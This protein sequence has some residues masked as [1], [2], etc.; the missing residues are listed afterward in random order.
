MI[1]LDFPF[2]L[3]RIGLI[4]IKFPLSARVHGHPAVPAPRRAHWRDVRGTFG[5]FA[6]FLIAAGLAGCAGGSP[7][8][9]SIP[10]PPTGSASAATP[11]HLS[12]ITDRD[13]ARLKDWRSTLMKAVADARTTD[14]EAVR[15]GGALFQPDAAL[16]RPMPPA[17]EYACSVAKLGSGHPGLLHFVA[18]PG[19]RCALTAYP[20][21]TAAFVKRTGSQRPVGTLYPADALHAVFLGTLQLS[22]ERAVLP[23]GRDADRDLVARVERI[24]PARWR[25]IF[26]APVYES[27]ADVIELVPAG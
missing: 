17:G 26:P 18:Y 14:A 3:C 15:V 24:G 21:G 2:L 8:S 4:I 7:L 22:D 5:G 25:M 16:D 13:R 11:S 10:A 27:I 9:K 20:D 19:F 1:A 6:P 23:Y 12:V